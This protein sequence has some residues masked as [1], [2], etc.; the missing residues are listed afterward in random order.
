MQYYAVR[1]KRYMET[2][3]V[4][5]PAVQSFTTL[6]GSTI[7][8]VGGGAS[9]DVDSRVAKAW[10]KWRDLTGSIYDKKVAT[11]M[12]LLIP[13]PQGSILP[14]LL[15]VCETWP[16]SVKDESVWQQQR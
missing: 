5:L 14:T 1:M 7:D 11:K 6:L 2:E 10:S 15:Y 16:V 4:N 13:I 9:K 8:R 3:T 12:K